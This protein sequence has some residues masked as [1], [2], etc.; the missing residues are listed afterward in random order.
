MNDMI[1]IISP[2][3]NL[4][5]SLNQH[6]LSKVSVEGNK[7][8]VIYGHTDIENE[9]TFKTNNDAVEFFKRLVCKTP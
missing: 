3:D 4:Y 1:V 2:E 8:F 5:L 9:L 6:L 7:V